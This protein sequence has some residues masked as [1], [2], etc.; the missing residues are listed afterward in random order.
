MSTK[1]TL[2]I[3]ESVISSAKEYAE[4]QGKSLS[5][6]VESYLKKLATGKKHKKEQ[7]S[8]V[9]KDLLGSVALPQNFNYKTALTEELTKRYLRK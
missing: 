6:I 5:D 8:P 3:E 1:L 7:F 4:R 2:I 9:I